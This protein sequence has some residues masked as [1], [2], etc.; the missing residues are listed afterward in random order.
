MILSRSK[1]FSFTG[2]FKTIFKTQI[3]QIFCCTPSLNGKE[4]EGVLSVLP[5]SRTRQDH[6]PSHSHKQWG[7]LGEILGGGRFPERTAKR[8]S[9][10]PPTAQEVVSNR[11]KQKPNFRNGGSCSIFEKT[12]LFWSGFRNCESQQIRFDFKNH[13]NRSTA[14]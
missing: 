14:I 9:V 10:L 2:C 8:G 5:E 6:L 11:A 1:V 3:T 7:Q 12:R 13:E 4:S